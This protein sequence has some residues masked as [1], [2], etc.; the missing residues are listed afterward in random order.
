LASPAQTPAKIANDKIKKVFVFIDPKLRLKSR[1]AG[2]WAHPG[3]LAP[4]DQIRNVQRTASRGEAV[5]HDMV[6]EKENC[7]SNEVQSGWVGIGVAKQVAFNSDP[8]TLFASGWETGVVFF[9]VAQQVLLA[10][11]P[12]RHAFCDGASETMQVRADP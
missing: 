3:R 8:E 1:C 10:Q 12:G 2:E 7:R 4:V 5:G 9:E 6:R 11:Q